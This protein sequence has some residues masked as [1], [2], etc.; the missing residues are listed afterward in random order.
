ME[1][2]KR[3]FDSIIGQNVTELETALSDFGSKIEF[4]PGWNFNFLQI[5]ALTGNQGIFDRVLKYDVSLLSGRLGIK[6]QLGIADYAMLGK[7]EY[8]ELTGYHPIVQWPD[9]WEGW[10]ACP[11]GTAFAMVVGG[12]GGLIYHVCTPHESKGG[13][14]FWLF[15]G[16]FGLEEFLMRFTEKQLFSHCKNYR[17]YNKI[18]ISKPASINS[19]KQFEKYII[20]NFSTAYVS[21]SGSCKEGDKPVSMTPL[22]ISA[23]NVESIPVTTVSL[24]L[25]DKPKKQ[26]I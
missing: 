13:L 2:A 7:R 21:L 1:K 6:E 19:F 10:V 17:G 23:V 24:T 26:D 16:G 4:T 5:A 9:F 3:V 8:S 14:F 25:C 11:L 15:L 20:E 22:E 12:A 18:D